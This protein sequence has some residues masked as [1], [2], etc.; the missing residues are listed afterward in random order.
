MDFA[1]IS[2]LKGYYAV[3]DYQRDYEWTDAQN[4]T[5]LEDILSMLS[6]D[7]TSHF[8]GAIVT[9]PF[10]KN[11]AANA[12]ID[13]NRYG[14]NVKGDVCHLVD[15]QQRL[16]SLSVLIRALHDIMEE[17]ESYV[18]QIKENNLRKLDGLTLGNDYDNEG[19][20][21]NPAPKLIL[22][23]NTGFYYL[24]DI[25]KKGDTPGKK[26]LKGAKR[27]SA[28]YKL[29]HDEIIKARN[30]RVIEEHLY[31]SNADFYKAFVDVITNKIVFVEIKCDGSSNA[32]Q[33]FD[34]LNGKGLDLTAADRIKN[35]MMS[36]STS[37]SKAQKWDA[38]VSSVGE[39]YLTSF[40]VTVFFYLIGK[41]VAKNKL[42]D[43]FK[44]S[45]AEQGKNYFDGFYNKLIAQA[46]LY[47][48]LRGCK[49]EHQGLIAKLDDFKRLGTDQVF[50][51][52]FAAAH[53]Y[54]IDL[55][56][57]TGE[58]FELCDALT[59]LIVRMQVCE[60]SMNKLDVL[61][62]SCISLMKND[63]GTLGQIVSKVKEFSS[64][65][66][67]DKQFEEAFVTFAP[68]DTNASEFYC[69][70]IEEFLRKQQE[71]RTPVE[72]GLTIEHI[73]PQT[74]K[75]LADW[76]GDYP[77]PEAIKEDPKSLLIERI[78]NK[79]LLYGDDNTSAGNRNYSKKCEV[80]KTGKRGQA[81][82]TPYATFAAVRDL[83]EKY[84]SQFNDSE[85][86]LRGKA[87]A[88]IAI[89]IW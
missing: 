43:Q 86:D 76:F 45:F 74:L 7:E 34:S 21:G 63:G 20:E 54:S 23:G 80:Y 9:I 72:R 71:I 14:I 5:L 16:T 62:S 47:G 50:V 26:N 18:G 11:N 78:A 33:V 2:D 27:L 59:S 36:W 51:I 82:G 35:I 89:K 53:H 49:A 61:F 44:D 6:T 79:M 29:Y 25:L 56:N 24:H 73:I 28:A 3:P 46:T 83:L 60:K 48:L 42:P 22:N 68:F 13:F 1:R 77:I 4:S 17:D 37:S 38:L 8:I 84:P 55:A 10:E 70:H 65:T 30:E 58:Y 15:G 81:N 69:R 12:C 88:K 57:P 39:D 31:E 40:F 75:D 67:T 85:M 52:L 66:V 87:L 64:K 32:F 41:R 19:E